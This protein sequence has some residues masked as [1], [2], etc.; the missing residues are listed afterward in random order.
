MAFEPTA[1]AASSL[2]AAASQ[3]GLAAAAAAAA[4][5]L[6]SASASD[7]ATP[8]YPWMSITGEKQSESLCWATSFHWRANFCSVIQ[9]TLLG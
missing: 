2:A 1:A 3:P 7:P 5:A 8:R 9:R 4:S 6:A